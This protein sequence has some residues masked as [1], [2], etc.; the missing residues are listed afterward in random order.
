MAPGFCT[1]RQCP[2][3]GERKL[4]CNRKS[5]GG[6]K[7]EYTF[8]IPTGLEQGY[9]SHRLIMQSNPYKIFEYSGSLSNYV[10]LSRAIKSA[11]YVP[12]VSTSEYSL[13]EVDLGCSK[14]AVPAIRL[15]K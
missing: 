1:Q 2:E 12:L 4:S 6:G 8:R 9:S 3:G 5:L 11:S 10:G 15:S 14:I 13:K 7:A